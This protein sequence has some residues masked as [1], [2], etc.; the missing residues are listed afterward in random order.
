MKWILVWFA[1]SSAGGVATSSAEFESE[2][3]CKAGLR[4]VQDTL[5]SIENDLK[6]YGRRMVS[7][8]CVSSQTGQRAKR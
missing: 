5:V 3:A 2:E 1:V 8:S 7:L 4:T 6:D